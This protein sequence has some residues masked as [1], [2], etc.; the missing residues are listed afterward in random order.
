LKWPDDYFQINHDLAYQYYALDNYN[1]GFLFS[2]GFANNLYFSETISRNSIDAPIYPRT[3][4]QI[5]LSAQF[6][7]P[8]SLF[9]NLDYNTATAQQRYKFIEYH[10]WK[11]SSTWY[12]RITGNLVLNTKMQYGFLGMYNRKVGASPFERFYIGGDGLTQGFMFDG[13]ELVA[14]RGYS[15]YNTITPTGGGTI[16]DK[17]TVELRHPITLNPSATIFVLA[18][19]EGGNA[20]QKFAQFNPF[21]LKRSAGAGVRIFLPIFGLLG[22]DYGWRFDEY[23]GSKGASR[24]HLSFTIGQQF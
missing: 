15:S 4:S 9:N 20:W 8:Y 22:L 17:Y 12:T 18:F 14:L 1:V 24:T 16:F 13:R 6:T 5:S 19:A 2:D 10:K 7:P 11:F 3:G 23:P 21:D